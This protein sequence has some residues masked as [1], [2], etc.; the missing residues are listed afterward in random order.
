MPV[1]YEARRAL[2]QTIDLSRAGRRD[3]ALEIVTTDRGK[4]YMD[5]LRAG[6]AEMREVEKVQLA[7]RTS[8]WE[9]SSTVSL[10]LIP[11]AA[12]R[13]CSSS[14]WARRSCRRTTS[15]RKRSNAGSERGRPSWP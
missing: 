6:I 4:R 13:C 9:R 3:Q 11:G 14:S 15:R 2:K 12:R 7:T 8:E 10:G 1:S 5:D